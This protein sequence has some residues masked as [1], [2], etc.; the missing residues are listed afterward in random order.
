MQPLSIRIWGKNN[1]GSPNRFTYPVRCRIEED[2]AQAA[3]SCDTQSN[4]V[5]SIDISLH[6]SESLSP[7]QPYIGAV[8][9]INN[10]VGAGLELCWLVDK[11]ADESTVQQMLGTPL[12]GLVLGTYKRFGIPDTPFLKSLAASSGWNSIIDTLSASELEKYVNCATLT[13]VS[14][15]EDDCWALIEKSKQS[16][17]SNEQHEEQLIKEL[18]TLAAEDVREFASFFRSKMIELYRWDLWAIGYI[19]N[20][21]CSDDG[22]TEFRAWLICQGREF[23]EQAVIRPEFVGEQVPVKALDTCETLYGFDLVAG[24][25]YEE[26]T[27]YEM[28]NLHP[29]E[30]QHPLGERWDENELSEIYPSISRKFQYR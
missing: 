10:S 30:P 12:L 16:S 5:K 15:D 7:R 18:S 19:I 29:L 21:G 6:L 24:P 25:I 23:F 13:P 20:G 14:I 3:S 28:H 27:G 11:S 22:F 9:I 4:I 17:A 1:S 2:L 8:S 26:K